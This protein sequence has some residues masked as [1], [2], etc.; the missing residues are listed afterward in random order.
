MTEANLQPSW[1]SYQW[2]AVFIVRRSLCT[3]PGKKQLYTHLATLGA[4]FI[5][6]VAEFGKVCTQFEEKP[7][8]YLTIYW[9]LPFVFHTP[10][11]LRNQK[12][13]RKPPKQLLLVRIIFLIQETLPVVTRTNPFIVHKTN[14][15]FITSVL[16][17]LP[18]AL[19]SPPPCGVNLR[20]RLSY[21]CTSPLYCYNTRLC[22]ICNEGIS[23][24]KACESPPS[25][26]HV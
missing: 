9:M 23:L 20:P 25:R 14:H 5:G 8:I 3:I 1:P 7:A 19:P 13:S 26:F 12:L 6:P 24:S 15:F 2:C 21:L 17:L 4:T 16:V 22:N 10:S 18:V 11:N